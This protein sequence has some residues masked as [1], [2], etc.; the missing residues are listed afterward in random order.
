MK[1][2]VRGSPEGQGL[3][4][5][6]EAKEWVPGGHHPQHFCK[7]RH[8]G[9][10]TAM[11]RAPKAYLKVVFVFPSPSSPGSLHNRPMNQR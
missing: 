4:V 6:A 2:F 9:T 10:S 11:E 8:L 3:R 5:S 7:G 1:S